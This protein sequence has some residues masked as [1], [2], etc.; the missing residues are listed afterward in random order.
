MHFLK[1]KKSFLKNI[2]QGLA[3]IGEIM[4]SILNF[5][6]FLLAVSVFLPGLAFAQSAG[7]GA[8]AFGGLMPLI[9][10]FIFFYLFLL[11]PQQ[12]KAKEHQALLNALKK[13]ERVITA[14]GIYGTVVRVEGNIVEVKI[15]EDVNI[16]V[17]KQSISAVIT[18]QQE[19]A[20]KTQITDIVKK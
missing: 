14:G 13:D 6:A 4:K 19:E 9:L 8:S 15:A 7:G 18:K 11:R 3:N 10:I 1:Q 5:V 16:Q 20:E 12:K 2:I 17:A